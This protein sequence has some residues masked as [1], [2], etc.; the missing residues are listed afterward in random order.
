M[1]KLKISEF[2]FYWRINS[3]SNPH[4]RIPSKLPYSFGIMKSTNMLIEKRSSKLLGD[5]NLVYKQNANIGFLINGHSLAKGYGEDFFK[6]LKSSLKYLDGKKILEIGCGGCY[7][8]EKLKKL[9]YDVYGID[10]SPFAIKMGNKKK[11]K[12]IK[13]FYPS[14]KISFPFDLIFHVDVLEHI[15]DPLLLLKEHYKNLKYG[16]YIVVNVPDS[17]DAVSLGDISMATHQHLN[18]FTKI[19]LQNLVEK[20]GFKVIKLAKSGFGGSLYCLALKKKGKYIKKIKDQELYNE[21]RNFFLKSKKVINR[22]NKILELS[23][24]Q[25]KNIGFYMPLRAFPY[26]AKFNKTFRYRLFDDQTHWHKRFID[27]EPTAIENYKDLLKNPVD[28]L[29]VM[30]ATF[31]KD[32]KKKILKKLPKIKIT[33]IKDLL[34]G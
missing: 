18:N 15:P 5:L 4:R 6:F 9:N 10:P 1:N 29:F 28:H 11:I 20:S 22:F 21:S 27:G 14:K 7:L 25:K 12:I 17:T 26:I 33:L 23:L 31:G 19:S 32:V 3:T 16:G 2:P 30:S 8:L 24:K 34:N 13:G